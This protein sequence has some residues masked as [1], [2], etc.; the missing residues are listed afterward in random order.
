MA[1][2]IIYLWLICYS[3]I[4]QRIEIMRDLISKVH[5]GTKAGSQKAAVNDIYQW[6]FDCE[7]V[8]ELSS[9]SGTGMCRGV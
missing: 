9:R 6:L 7:V 8:E 2:R 3:K 5:K 1:P 4:S